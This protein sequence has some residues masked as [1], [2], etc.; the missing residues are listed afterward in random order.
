MMSPLRNSLGTGVWVGLLMV[1]VCSFGI[2][3]PAFAIANGQWEKISNDDGIEVFKREVKDDP[4]LGLK[5]QGVVDAPIAKVI[6]VLLD[7]TR[8]TEWI[9]SCV[10]QKL[11]RKIS[12]T[13][14]VEY[15]HIGTPI[16]MKDREFVVRNT[17]QAD[18][19]A[20]TFTVQVKS[21][22]DPAAPKT[23]YIR[24]EV[25]NSSF[26]LKS[27]D[28]GTRTYVVA[29]MNADPKGSVPKWVVNLF[30]KKWPRNTIESL[31]KQVARPDVKADPYYQ[32]V[33]EEKD[34]LK[35]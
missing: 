35:P 10:E 6:Q 3:S 12:L 34:R 20:K 21:V 25:K 22:E 31:R 17:I 1:L 32:K 7:Y 28:H 13:E 27:L 16:V 14:D 4:L 2:S 11:I 30:Q 18:P 19:I 5:G 24:G 15:S 9:D 33:F 29:E 23:D 26:F 8:A